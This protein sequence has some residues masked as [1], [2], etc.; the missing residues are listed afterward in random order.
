MKSRKEVV[1]RAHPK[2]K[3]KSE[4][5]GAPVIVEFKGER[6]EICSRCREK[7]VPMRRRISVV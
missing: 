5:C 4:C 6:H 1:V 3:R 7:I 2:P